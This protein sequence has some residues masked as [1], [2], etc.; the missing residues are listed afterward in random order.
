[1]K[2]S[3]ALLSLALAQD[4]DDASKDAST[5][6]GDQDS[7][8]GEQESYEPQTSYGTASYG[9]AAP[10]YIEHHKICL[11][12]CFAEAPCLNTETGACQPYS[13]GVAAPTYEAHEEYGAAQEQYGAAQEQSGYRRLDESDNSYGY[14][15][16]AQTESYSAPVAESYAAPAVAYAAPSC[17]TCPEGTV[18]AGCLRL[19]RN[20]PL[21]VGFVLLFL[22]S[23]FFVCQ[24]W[25]ILSN[26]DFGLDNISFQSGINEDGTVNSRILQFNIIALKK[27]IASAILLIA[28]MAYLTMASGHGYITRCCDGRSFYYAR[29]IDWF[30]TTPLMLWELASAV[31]LTRSKFFLIFCLDIIMIV[32]GLVASLICSGEKWIFWGFGVL[33][34]VPILFVLCRENSDL[35]NAIA[36][37]NAGQADIWTFNPFNSENFLADTPVVFTGTIT[38][39]DGLAQVPWLT[40]RVQNFKNALNIT[41]VTWFFYPIVWIFAEGTGD[42]CSN[43]EAICYTVLDVIAKSVFAFAISDDQR[44]IYGDLVNPGTFEIQGILFVTAGAKPDT[45][46]AGFSTDQIIFRLN[47]GCILGIRQL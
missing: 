32:T 16:P 4:G 22:P 42:F 34:F 1:M 29:Y 15:A 11:G 43:A 14:E 5:T 18:D 10:A 40:Q 33:S 39:T 23:L 31:D 12:G 27:V 36:M 2:I 25:E 9:E 21:W 28:S 7:G 20:W 38:N 19:T 46:T 17:D 35:G 6:Q 44:R 13:C 3:A 30:F 26:N 47:P 8:Y 37:F 24:F 41:V 45:R